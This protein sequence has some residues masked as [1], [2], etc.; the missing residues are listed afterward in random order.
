MKR[1]VLF[2]P[3]LFPFLLATGLLLVNSSCIIC[4]DK[5]KDN[6]EP[7][8]PEQEIQRHKELTSQLKEQKELINQLQITLLEKHTEI[9]KLTKANERLVREF[10]RRNAHTWNKR[11]KVETVRLL[12]EVATIIKTVRENKSAGQSKDLFLRVEEYLAESRIEL[13]KGNFDGAAYLA[14]QALEQVQAIRLGSSTVGQEK[15]DS[16]INFLVPLPMK[17]TETCNVRNGPSRQA[18]VAFVLLAGNNVTAIGYKKPWVKV[19][20]NGKKSGWIHQ[21]LLNGAWE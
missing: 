9:D 5:G 1:L 19:K 6:H 12:A 13:Q 7:L 15:N 17:I 20:V 4:K 3:F 14:E 21:T 11:D 8:L 10:V 16:I 18:K 2:Q